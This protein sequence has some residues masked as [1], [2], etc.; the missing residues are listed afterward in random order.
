MGQPRSGRKHSAA[1]QLGAQTGAPGNLR[2]SAILSTAKTL[3]QNVNSQ[4]QQCPLNPLASLFP[5]L[6]FS[7]GP[8]GPW[9]FPPARIPRLDFKGED[10]GTFEVAPKD[11]Q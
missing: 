2:A 10:W 4:S 5:D 8:E 9:S 7:V 3:H 6:S 11:D 1:K